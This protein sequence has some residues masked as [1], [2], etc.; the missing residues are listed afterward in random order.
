MQPEIPSI[1]LTPIPSG[2]TAQDKVRKERRD[3]VILILILAVLFVAYKIGFY[4]GH[5]QTLLELSRIAEDAALVDDYF[6]TH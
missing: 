6:Q 1:L 3:T 2:P 5:K 4:G